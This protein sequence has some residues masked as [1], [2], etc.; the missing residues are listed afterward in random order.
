MI[1][2]HLGTLDQGTEAFMQWLKSKD[3]QSTNNPIILKEFVN[4]KPIVLYDKT[5]NYDVIVE[6]YQ[7][8]PKCQS[9]RADDCEHKGFTIL[10]Q[11]YDSQGSI[12][13]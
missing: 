13:D 4:N 8:V 12:L 5:L 3:K 6:T 11:K 7:G 9:C 1:L 10:E 2:P